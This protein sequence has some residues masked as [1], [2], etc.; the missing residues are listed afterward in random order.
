MRDA[1]GRPARSSSSPKKPSVDW[2]I[3]DRGRESE[4][5]VPRPF[6][7]LTRPSCSSRPSA[8]RIVVRDRP[9]REH[10]SLSDGTRVP[11]AQR[12]LTISSSSSSASW[13]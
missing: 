8:W 1:T 11:D 7:R 2:I 13:K 12:P 10:S 9:Y 5:N 3:H 6:S 4:T